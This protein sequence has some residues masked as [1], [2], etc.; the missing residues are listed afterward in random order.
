MGGQLLLV[1]Q[2]EL[3]LAPVRPVGVG[4]GGNPSS[5]SWSSV[6]GF[7]AAPADPPV[8]LDTLKITSVLSAL[9]LLTCRPAVGTEVP[10][11]TLPLA[12][13]VILSES[14]VR[15]RTLPVPSIPP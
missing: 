13:T 4:L 10:M 2:F 11:P 15:T 9:A 12:A 5:R 14:L 8:P 3:N 1:G 7:F 6:R